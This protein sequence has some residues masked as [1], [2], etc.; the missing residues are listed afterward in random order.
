MTATTEA[1]A[2][3]GLLRPQTGRIRRAAARVLLSDHFVLWLSLGYFL[4]LLPFLPTL[5]TPANLANLLSN[6]WPLLVVA[7]G[8]TF[9]MTAGG[10]D[11][12]Q[13]AVIGLTSTVAAALI[14]TAAPP[15]VL[16]RAPIWGTLIAEEGGIFA[17]QVWVGILAMLA[18]GA[19]VGLVNGTLVALLRM[20]PFMVTLVAMMTVSAFAI[21]LTQ[22]E[23]IRNL[24]EGYV[25]LGKGQIVSVYFGPQDRPEIPRRELHAVI[26]QAALIAVALTLALHWLLERTAF[27]RQ[28]VA[29]G[30][31]RRAAE[32]AGVPVRRVIVLVFVLSALCATV[33]AILYSARLEAGRPTLG[34]GTFLLD[35]IGAT[36]I[37]GTSLFGGKGKILWTVWGVLFFVLLSN[38]LNMMNLS[39]FHIDM[40]KGAVILAAALLDVARNRLARSTG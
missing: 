13:G 21:W 31:N 6:A 8:Q 9:V 7:L 38:T 24:P 10:I 36:V 37:G 5:G 25:Q 39:A 20:P 28:V 34:E 17:G 12:S 26:G 1:Q 27:G 11:L 2:G 32:I 40:V 29:V 22:S 30:A 18:V 4:V 15:E 16:G 23:N 33:G 3:T 19:L 35:V 14:A